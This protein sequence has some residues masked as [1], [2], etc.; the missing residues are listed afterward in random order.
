[1]Q[2]FWAGV[3]VSG[4]EVGV[5]WAGGKVSRGGL[6]AGQQKSPAGG[7]FGKGTKQGPN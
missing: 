2:E 3:R 6:E 4:S 5:E 1:M 7:D